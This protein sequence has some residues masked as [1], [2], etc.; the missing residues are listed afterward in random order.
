MRKKSSIL[1]TLLIA[2]FRI[3]AQLD[4]EHYFAPM[5]AITVGG[6]IPVGGD[7]GNQYLYLATPSTTPFTVTITDGAG[8]VLTT[9]TISNTS[10]FEYSVGS[11]QSATT[12]M[13]VSQDQLNTALTGRGL[14]IKGP[15]AFTASFKTAMV[16]HAE[17]MTSKGKSAKG[18]TFRA[19]GIPIRTTGT[20]KGFFTSFMATEPGTTTISVSGYNPAVEFDGTPVVTADNLTITLQQGQAY[21]LAG[22]SSKTANTDGFL[23]AL[24]TSDKD[25]VVEHGAILGSIAVNGS[26]QDVYFDQS[27]PIERVGKDYILIQGGGE[28]TMELPVLVA[29]TNN[30]KIFTNGSATPIASIN[31]GQYYVVPNSN[32]QNGSMYIKTSEPTY[33]FQALSGGAQTNGG[34]MFIPP[35]NC[36]LPNKINIPKADGIGT[37]NYTATVMIFTQQGSTV[38]YNGA[39]Q[40]GA[41]PVA[42]TQWETYKFNVSGNVELTSTGAMSASLFGVSGVASYA[43]SYAGFSE[44][45]NKSIITYTD[46]CLNSNTSFGSTHNV[47]ST[48]TGF[49]WN[50]GD[51]ASGSANTS[52]Q[53]FPTHVFSAVGTYN[54]QLIITRTT[55]NDTVIQPVKI[56]TGKTATITG[57]TGACINSPQPTLTITGLNGTAPYTF[58]YK[59]NN[60]TPQTISSGVGSTASLSVPTNVAGT[61]KYYLTAVSDANGPSTCGTL[62][63]SITV[64]VNADLPVI[65]NSVDLCF[66]ETATLTASGATDYSWTPSTGLSATT[67][68]SVT[69]N[70]T[71][72]TTYTVTGT[73][74]GCT[75]VATATVTVNP[76]PSS[77][78]GADI[79][80]CSGAS[81]N[82]GAA[83]TSGYIYN[84]APNT[85]LSSSTVANPSVSLT[86][87]SG[88]PVV[89]SYTVTTSPA[90]CFSMDV[91][92]VTV[93]PSLDPTFNY[94]SATFC[95]TLV[96]TNPAPT[97]TTNGGTFSSSPAGLSIDAATGL[98]DLSLSNVGTYTVT[99]SFGGACP[100]SSTATITITNTPVA[101]FTLGTYCQNQTN[102]L[103]TFINGGSAGVFSSASVAFVSTTTGE[104][105]LAASPTGTYSVTNT[106]GGGGGCP[107]ASFTNTI[108]INA[109]P[110]VSVNNLT[111]CAGDN[112]TLNANGANSYIWEDASTLNTLSVSPLV[113][114]SY[115]VTGTTNNCSSTITAT[116]TVNPLP[117]V[118][119]NNASIC[120]GAA[121]T[122]SASGAVSYL[123]SDNTTNNA[124]TVTPS[125]ASSYTVTGTSLNCS[126]SAV[127]SVTV[128]TPPNVTV[129]SESICVGNSTVLTATGAN[130]YT[131]SD[132]STGNSITVSPTTNTTY[133]V[134]GTTLSCNNTAVATVSV[135]ALPQITVN[136]PSVCFGQ[137]VLLTASGGASYTWMPGNTTGNS[138]SVSPSAT[139]TYTVTDATPNCSGQA[140][141][142]VT[143]N[144]I[145]VITINAPTICS[146][147]LVQLTAS[148]AVL[149]LWSNNYTLNPL[150]VSPLT[151]TSYSIT[152]TT[153]QGCVGIGSTTVTVKPLPI[154]TI[155]SA[156]ICKGETATLTA[157]GA[158]S[159]V[160]NNGDT[161]PS[162]TVTPNKTT[163]YSVIGTGNNS[164]INNINTTVKVFPKPT[165][166]FNATPNPAKM[167]SPEVTF[168]S[169]SSPDISNWLWN[170]GDGD[171]ATAITNTITHRYPED[172]A[173]YNVTL[174]VYNDGLCYDTISHFVEIGPEFGFYAPNAFSPNGD[175]KNDIF[176]IQGTGILEFQLSIFDRWGNFV[177]YSDDIN[178]GWD[179]IINGT[180]EISIQDTYIWKLSVTNVFKKKLE[181]LGSVTIVQ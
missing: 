10:P 66:G 148:G 95:K 52:T 21:V 112:A 6:I 86:N 78:A 53:E 180:G 130:S 2:A 19:G 129:N 77:N 25:I 61:F 167:L 152:G 18:K 173:T 59:I 45:P 27:A 93:N 174:I 108:T 11:G 22:T 150:P 84:W 15:Q 113:T 178:K 26:G 80:I 50:F 156:T 155:N 90:G 5:H 46:T 172:T 159:Y 136:N 160:W 157:A 67:G 133:T 128:N 12:K 168:I 49:N 97:I 33:V 131:W 165:A 31:A 141:A 82:I 36:Y 81:G 92:N 169:Q 123:W 144:P 175:D 9:A 125:A 142:T 44:I 65:V 146:G 20:D 96:A 60:G 104:I 171:S 87:Y 71:I 43:G 105:N 107:V 114:T 37:T 89:Y 103:P 68:S 42:G 140:T 79:S 139:T 102:P 121:A 39:V 138:L 75:G 72:N 8:T 151:T 137:S 38:K 127:A 99:Y 76:I 24:I 179:G 153:A 161:N 98:I 132:N 29:H 88:A 54:V 154:I 58:T 117:T 166:Q 7:G 74:S 13:F 101:D 100:S 51:P 30:T 143:I 116:V 145:P 164:C 162:I 1:F 110:N 63:D 40:G 134:T 17:L 135:R 32:Y 48:I 28:P 181:Y 91:V 176:M 64:T 119:V 47:D 177:F 109:V 170:F 120:Q 122:L 55:C 158:N 23:G 41:T 73:N 57:T 16:A 126:A 83:P 94:S 115:S 14:I 34:M 85:G 3:F 56:I 147:E 70:P 62:S 149:Y 106:F 35:F 111:I 118:T 163:N 69:A 124:I 4:T